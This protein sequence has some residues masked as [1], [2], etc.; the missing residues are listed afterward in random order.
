MHLTSREV[1]KL[2]I[3]TGEVARRRLARGLQLNHPEALVLI[4][5]D[6]LELSR[7]GKSV[8][9]IMSIGPTILPLEAVLE[10]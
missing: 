10:G 2:I 9:E 7:D 8:A 1:D 3:F 4:T 6:V 5:A